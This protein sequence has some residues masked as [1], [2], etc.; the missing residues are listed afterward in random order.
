MLPIH[1]LSPSHTRPT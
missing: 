1:L